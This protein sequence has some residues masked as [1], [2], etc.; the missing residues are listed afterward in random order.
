[1]PDH[2]GRRCA[3]LHILSCTVL[4]SVLANACGGGDS[5]TKPGSVDRTV[6]R[7]VAGADQTDTISTQLAQALVV[8]IHDTTGKLLP[9]ATVRFTSLTGT[10]SVLV[11]SVSAQSFGSFV[12]DAADAQGRAKT[13]VRLGLFAG[14]AQIEVNVP[15]LG[16]VD[17]INFTVKPGAPARFTI[18][19]RDTSIPPGGSYT[20][21]AQ[22]MDRFS[23]PLPG[24]VPTLSASG[25]N[26]TPAGLVTATSPLARGVIT[27]SYQGASDSAF[28][29]VIP[30]LPMVMNR[31]QSVVVINSDG[32]GATTLASSFDQSLA[33]S[34][35]A[36]TSSVV[37][38]QGDPGYSGKVWVAQPNQS[39][40]VLLPGVTRPE[41]WPSLS[42]D[43]TWVYFVRDYKS[44]WRVR[45][46]GTG[47]DSLTS[48]TEARIYAAPTISPDGQS[49]AI[50]DGTGVKIVDV[51]TKATRRLSVTCPYPRYSPDGVYFACQGAGFLAIVKSDGTGYRTVANVL[52]SFDELSGIDWTPDGK[53][54]L[55]NTIY[56]AAMLYEVATGGGIKL[57]GLGVVF[58]ASFVR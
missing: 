53:W 18:T 51:A 42:P 21:K 7:V 29:A 57:S 6:I 34:A 39:P 13:L 24:A 11:S 52:Y 49:V 16:A 8:E 5:P 14:P 31:G 27:V 33:P 47:L 4:I 37:Y 54:L 46:D 30:K 26:I 41:G 43:G 56:P 12:S 38:Y 44:L 40:R 20:L 3:P 50:E 15:E 32:T 22:T 19:P 35:V 36:S 58:Q 25:V 45:L 48:F 55:V 2:I 28:V 17:T 23:N 10:G 1:M 9:G